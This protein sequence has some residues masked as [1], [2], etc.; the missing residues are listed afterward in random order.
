MIPWSVSNV[1]IKASR[2]NGSLEAHT[3]VLDPES[4]SP[5][6]LQISWYRDA[7][8]R[9]HCEPGTELTGIWGAPGLT[10]NS[11]KPL[12]W[13]LEPGESLVLDLKF[14]EDRTRAIGGPRSRKKWQEFW[15]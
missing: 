15:L 12:L 9:G 3:Y 7:C 8:G 13:S 5:G 10:V 6:S 14:G 1:C 2:M 11:A 4:A